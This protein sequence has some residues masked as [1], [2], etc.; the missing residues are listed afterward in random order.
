MQDLNLQAGQSRSQT[1][2]VR[3]TERPSAIRVKPGKPDDSFLVLKIE[4]PVGTP[5]DQ[6]PVWCAI[7]APRQ[8]AVCPSADEVTAIRQW[9]TECA[10]DN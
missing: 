10:P 9:I 8:G 5:G 2:N 4:Y 3:S 1:V 7:D 6:M